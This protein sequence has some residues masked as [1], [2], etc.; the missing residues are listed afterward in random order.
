MGKAGE[1]I[2]VVLI[3]IIGVATLAVILSRN[4][5]TTNVIQAAAGGFSQ[6]LAAALAPITGQS[7]FAGG[8]F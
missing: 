7:N 2:V 3:A 8:G 4:S 5:N 6:S 1:Q